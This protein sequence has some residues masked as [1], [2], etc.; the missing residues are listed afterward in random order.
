MKMSKAKDWKTISAK[1]TY[2]TT[3][4]NLLSTKFTR[5]ILQYVPKT[6]EKYC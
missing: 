5:S 6:T 4:Q 2:M 3:E 1:I